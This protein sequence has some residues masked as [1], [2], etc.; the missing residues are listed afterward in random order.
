MSAAPGGAGAGGGGCTMG[1]LGGGEVG[2]AAAAGRGVSLSEVADRGRDG[3]TGAREEGAI[4]F[5]ALR[6]GSVVGEHKVILA[7]P[8]ERIEIGHIAEDRAIFA[9]GALTAA[10][11]AFGREPGLYSMRDV[12]GLNA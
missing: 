11:W 2:E 12:L 9:R 4:G 10:R 3:L 5:A 7:G 8:S 6:G 1:A